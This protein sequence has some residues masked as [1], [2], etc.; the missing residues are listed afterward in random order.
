MQAS[1]VA[2]T[3]GQPKELAAKVPTRFRSLTVRSPAAFT[4]EECEI[5]TSAQITGF[6]SAE[7]GAE[8]VS[9]DGDIV[10]QMDQLK[11]APYHSAVKEDL[12]GE[13]N[14]MLRVLW[15]PDPYG[16]GYISDAHA[17]MLFE[18]FIREANSP[19][20]DDTVLKLGALL[21]LLVHKNP[22]L[23]VLEVGN[24]IHDITLAALDLLSARSE[25]KRMASYSTADITEDGS[26]FGGAVN[27]ENG[28]RSADPGVLE[29]GHYDLAVIP[30][31]G[32]WLAGRMDRLLDAMAEDMTILALCPGSTS[33]L[34]TSCSSLSCVSYPVMDGQAALVLAR[35]KPAKAAT[36][37]IK[38]H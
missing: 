29:N 11:L 20:S 25:F 9:P 26:L 16:L 2:T 24:A 34:I 36:D 12:D 35:M 4:G 38:R 37:T 23:H 6:G 19:V 3:S 33:E 7:V 14:P 31:V 15:K 13:R 28:E 32:S 27:L 30:V 8:L 10:V 18:H 17:Q 1:I 22:R 21:D 5:R